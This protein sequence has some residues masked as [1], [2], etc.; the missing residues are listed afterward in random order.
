MFAPVYTVIV[1]A[2]F[3][4]YYASMIEIVRL[5][6]AE[7]RT[8]DEINKLLSALSENISSCTPDLLQRIVG[9]PTVEI[10]VAKHEGHIVGIGELAL[11]LKLEGISAYIEDVVVA[12]PERGKGIGT[13]I[14]KKLIERARV[15]GA[16]EIHLT[17]RPD[18][19]AA[20]KLYKKLGF[21]MR[22]TNAY[23]LKL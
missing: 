7:Q 14:M 22:A 15:H 1:G 11:V 6:G 18:R 20:N 3:R 21:E 19:V 2:S 10:W 5:D 23:C 4:R 17:S 8:L 12:I 13:L 16:Q 9:N